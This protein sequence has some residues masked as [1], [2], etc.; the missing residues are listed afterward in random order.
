M[1]NLLKEQRRAVAAPGRAGKLHVRDSVCRLLEL[2]IANSP[3]AGERSE[4]RAL[5]AIIKKRK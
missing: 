3:K 5:R 2:F 4:A 1:P